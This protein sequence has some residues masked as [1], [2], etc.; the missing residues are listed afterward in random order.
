[1]Y[2]V[3]L[4]TFNG[5]K[6]IR[7][8]IKSIINQ[9]IIPLTIYVGDDCSTDNTLSIITDELSSTNIRLIVTKN[10]TNLGYANN[11]ISTLQNCTEEIIFLSDQDDIWLPNKAEVILDAFS[12]NPNKNL[13]FSDAYITNDTLIPE[14]KSLSEILKIKNERLTLD[15]K[16]VKGNI[17]TGATMAIRS[18]LI[19]LSNNIPKNVPHDYWIATLSSINDGILWLPD[20]LIKYRQHSNN[21]LGAK[22]RS[23]WDRILGIFNSNHYTLRTLRLKERYSIFHTLKDLKILPESCY[24]QYEFLRFLCNLSCGFL[25]PSRFKLLFLFY[26]F[27]Y[28]YGVKYMITDI[29]L[30]FKNF[31][32]S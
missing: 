28:D 15:K 3:V 25:E 26:Y 13:V 2:A 7:E 29:V 20:K 23:F 8:Q 30:F 22:E 5:E 27:R 10:T 17:V 21:V 11:F 9:T 24:E 6:Y 14:S 31:K 4:C 16:F 32:R 18:S 19:Y 12:R 1:M